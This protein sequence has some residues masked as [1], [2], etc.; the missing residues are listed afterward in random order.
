MLNEKKFTDIP[1]LD[2]YYLHGYKLLNPF[3]RIIAAN[4]QNVHLLESSVRNK[5]RDAGDQVVVRMLMDLKNTADAKGWELLGLDEFTINAIR[6]GNVTQ[7][8]EEIANLMPADAELPSAKKLLKRH[9]KLAN[10]KLAALTELLKDTKQALA[11]KPL[12]AASWV[13]RGDSDG[14]LNYLKTKGVVFPESAVSAS[15]QT[16]GKNWE[17]NQFFSTSGGDVLASLAGRALVWIIK[18]VPGQTKG[19]IGGLYASESEVLFPY[20]V[21]FRLEGRVTI[22]SEEDISKL[23]LS[24]FQ[25]PEGLRAKLYKVYSTNRSSWKTRPA[26]FLIALER[27]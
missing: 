1:P 7:E 23:Q 8:M 27:Q 3:C 15:C 5:D 17:T 13:I 21:K 9:N 19:R 26:R 6:N 14:M 10:K 4:P 22:D 12:P 20:D 24:A 16:I 18:I 11:A 2:Y 25:D